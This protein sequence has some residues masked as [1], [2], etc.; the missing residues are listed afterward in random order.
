MRPHREGKDL[1]KSREKE[2]R[3]SIYTTPQLGGGQ[4]RYYVSREKREGVHNS[5]KQSIGEKHQRDKRGESE[6]RESDA[7]G[8]CPYQRLQNSVMRCREWG[9]REN[10]TLA[11]ERGNRTKGELMQ[12]SAEGDLRIQS[13]T[14]EAR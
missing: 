11:E 3:M 13:V 14:I 8:P 10:A 5:A 1:I 7:I 9:L 2:E 4:L 6:S 12:R